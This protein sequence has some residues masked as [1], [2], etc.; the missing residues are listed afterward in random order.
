[1]AC[2]S[3]AALARASVSLRFH[4]SSA[5]S[6]P[7]SRPITSDERTWRARR[8][9]GLQHLIARRVPKRIV[10]R[11][12]AVDVEHDQRAARV[13]AFDV[14]DRAVEFALEAAPVGNIQQEIGIGG[15]LQFVDSRLRLRQL[16]PQPANGRFGVIGRSRRTG[17]GAADPSPGARRLRFCPLRR[18]FCGV[19]RLLTRA[20]WF[21]SSWL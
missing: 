16:G 20:P 3:N 13:I 18:G 8:H 17:R 6:S 2:S 19:W 10:D 21:S 9:N 4:N 5:N 7:P 1:M 11:L 15:R 14:G 12:E